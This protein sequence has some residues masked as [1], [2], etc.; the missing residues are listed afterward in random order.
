MRHGQCIERSA[1]RPVSANTPLPNAL[2]TFVKSAIEDRGQK[3]IEFDGSFSLHPP[4]RTN[5][6]LQ[7]VKLGNN[8]SLLRQPWEF[9][10]ES[11]KSAY[12]EVR[13]S[14]ALGQRRYL[15]FLDK[16]REKLVEQKLGHDA[17]RVWP[18]HHYALAEAESLSRLDKRAFSSAS[19][20]TNQNDVVLPWLSAS[21][22]PT[23]L[24]FVGSLSA[25]QIQ[26]S[27]SNIG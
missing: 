17:V 4:Q 20:F 16:W 8:A 1:A 21:G 13:R 19:S 10:V 12:V 26:S 5:L 11:A 6:C 23:I 2:N 3:R 24:R 22:P 7:R 14:G 9:Q 18:E 25:L 15:S 27:V